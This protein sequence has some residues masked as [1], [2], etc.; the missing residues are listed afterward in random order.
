MTT[1]LKTSLQ[2]KVNNLPEFKSEALLPVF[3]AVVNSIQA[4]EEF[5]DIRKGKITIRIKRDAQCNL[6]VISNDQQKIIGFDIIDDGIG[7]NETNYDSFLTS[8]TIHKIGKGCKG[9]GRFFWLKAFRNVRI[10]SVYV[11]N[12]E[13]RK[14]ILS[15]TTQ[16]GISDVD[17][18]L[19]DEVRQTKVEL[20]D[21]QEDYRKLPS[22]Y[23][24][25]EKIAQRILEHCL[26]YFIAHQAP[27]I[28]VEDESGTT[29]FLNTLFD[30]IKENMTIED[31]KIAGEQ[32]KIYHLKLYSTYSKMHNLVFCASNREVKTFNIE[33]LLGTSTQFDERDSRFIY[34]AY[35]S[36]DYLDK[37]V[38]QSRIDFEI[39]AKSSPLLGDAFILS[40]E[41]L[42]GEVIKKSKDF[43][44]PYLKLLAEKKREITHEYVD[45]KNP[46]LR[47]VLN[48]C[49]EV[50]DE[51]DPTSSEEEVDE[52]LY[53]YKGKAEFQI[54]KKSAELLKTQAESLE[55]VKIEYENICQ[56]IE[57]FQKDQLAGYM[58]FRKMIIDLLSKK[59]EINKKDGNYYTEKII[60]D[61]IFPRYSSSDQLNLEGHNMWLIDERLTF[62]SFAKSEGRLC[63][64]ND[65]ESRDRPDILVFSEVDDD[66]IARTISIVE[67]KR[68][69]RE[70]YD[71]DP[72]KQLYRYVRNIQGRKLKSVNG[73]TIA[74]GESTRFYC[75]AI[76]D[77]TD[78]IV[79]YAENN[80]FPKL[81]GGLGYS[82]YNSKMNVY[83]EIIDF[84]KIVADAE[85]R[86]KIFFAKL[87]I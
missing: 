58:L 62:H 85:Q 79:E 64:I 65:S 5:G 15:F 59:I 46:A 37:N 36:G 60:H 26:S 73:R 32:F 9:I 74:V 86:H 76:C 22:A 75:Y 28:T 2:G 51:I 57:L 10:S 23:K 50:Y 41:E 55:G 21:F 87:G 47:A 14:R 52:I 3:E 27:S 69:Q 39:P 42:K 67:L 33:S 25:T 56:K 44:M 66:R 11:T 83:L 70:N 68:P 7:F 1:F 6:N 77:L 53:K 35:V 17:D 72:T 20:N 31:I 38:S 71:E 8:D 78:Q 19:S 45:K 24:K 30:Q 12:N 4:I 82:S 43:L 48:Y 29:I 49:P 81:K 16:N 13:K 54:R 40:M 80:N 34:S 61:I 63:D 18:N 84:D